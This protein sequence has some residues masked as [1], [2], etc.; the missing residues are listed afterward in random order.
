[1]TRKLQAGQGNFDQL[2]TQVGLL[3]WLSPGP[4]WGLR[5]IPAYGPLIALPSVL[6][7]HFTDEDTKA[8]GGY[9][10]CPGPRRVGGEAG[11]DSGYSDS[12]ALPRPLSVEGDLEK[13]SARGKEE[14][15]VLG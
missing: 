1:M 2:G 14:E 15:E 12:E 4:A 7:A 6:S 11:L 13:M 8:Q 3:A 9:V 5:H 10:L